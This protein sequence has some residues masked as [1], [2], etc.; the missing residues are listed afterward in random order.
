MSDYLKVTIKIED[1][2]TGGIEETVFERV[3]KLLTERSWPEPQR[4]PETGMRYSSKPKDPPTI[5]LTVQPAADERGVWA[6]TWVTGGPIG[7]Q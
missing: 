5:V 4:D 2:E 3:S 6:T 1:P 7:G